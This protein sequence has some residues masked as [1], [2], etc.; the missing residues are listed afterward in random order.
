[1]KHAKQYKILAVEAR[2]RELLSQQPI[3][4]R[5]VVKLYPGFHGVYAIS[6]PL[7]E[8]IIY[9]GLSKT[10]KGGI[11][12]RLGDHINLTGK[13]A[14]SILRTFVGGDISLARSYLVRVLQVDDWT[15]RRNIEAVAIGA[16]S[17]KFN[18]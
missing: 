15:E 2:V 1:M 4:M 16:L 14:T 7:D 9:V 5:E 6:D 17:P 10:A 3:T 18:K 11:G 12:Q 8:E 13:S